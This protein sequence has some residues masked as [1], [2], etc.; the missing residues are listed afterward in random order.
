VIQDYLYVYN[1]CDSEQSKFLR[2]E[3]DAAFSDYLT[4]HSSDDI[5]EYFCSFRDIQTVVGKLKCG[6]STATFLRAEHVMNSSY[7]L[8]VHLS[9]L[10]SAII[11]HGYVPVKFLKGVISPIVKD[12]E[13]DKS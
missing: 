12:P 9:I 8:L 13:S 10:F 6:K 5:S 7:K 4:Q 3:F 11:Q 1:C 2:G